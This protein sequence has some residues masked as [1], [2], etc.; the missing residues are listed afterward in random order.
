MLAENNYR[1]QGFGKSLKGLVWIYEEADN[2]V[3]E[4]LKSRL[5]ISEIL[6]KIL[7]NR[8]ITDPDA[9]Q[10][11]LEPKLRNLMANPFC[12]KD[13]DRAVERIVR[14]IYKKER[15]T[16]FGDYDVDGAT[17]TALLRRFFR[18]I[19]Y[20]DVGIYIPSRMN[21]GYG[22]SVEAFEK[23]KQD[24]TSLII[25]VD[26]GVVSFEP[27]KH[28]NTIG[29]DV[30]VLDHHLSGD[31]LP[32][33][34]AIVNPNR[35]DDPFEF[36]SLAAVSIAFFAVVGIR[37]K[38]REEGYF[39]GG[40]EVDVMQYMDLVALGTVCDVMQLHGV[41]RAFVKNG[42]K[43]IGARKNVGI[44]TLAN[45]AKLDTVPQSYHLGFVLGPRINAGGRVGEGIL[46]SDLLYTE[47]AREALAIADRLEQLNEERRAIENAILETALEN[48]EK[49]NLH[50]KNIVMIS[51][52]D[53]HQGVLGILASRIKEKYNRPAAVVS[54]LDGVGKGSARSVPGIDFGTMLAKAK[55]R[56]L[57]LQGGG[58]AMAGGFAVEEGKIDE[59]YSFML[60][61]TAH[62]GECIERVKELK[63]DAVLSISAITGQL[64]REINKAAPFGNG[65][66]NPRFLV[67]NVKVVNLKAIGRNHLMIIVA[68]PMLSHSHGNSLKCVLFKAMDTE[69]GQILAHSMGKHINIL[70]S[71][72]ENLYDPR[73]ADFILEDASFVE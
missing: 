24:G 31:Q 48:I 34:Y 47:D 49:Q 64:V 41:N 11:F 55:D 25:T 52:Y 71:L 68:D 63:V 65:N 20:K 32:P 70:G 3:I 38:L 50:H 29:L 26:C 53:W 73:K 5:S 12:F 62:A 72:Q 37:S 44:A 56:G 36:K 45:I 7:Y 40:E 8:N 39:K 1:G 46:G 54:V 58:H 67:N 42:L 66:P 18:D 23:I 43:L 4:H 28:A 60:E 61:S 13:M 16:I 14:A 17:S 30:V 51:G 57:L 33:A 2:N 6:A 69:I 59:F 22:P 35:I 9:A 15:I 10:N 27:I 21:E 19:G